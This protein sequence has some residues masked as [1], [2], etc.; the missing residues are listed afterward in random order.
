MDN[1][2]LEGLV[3]SILNTRELVLN[4]GGKNGVAIGM[5]FKVLE[6]DF[7]IR[8]PKSQEVLG[9]IQREKIKIKIVDV[10]DKISI[11]RTY[12]TYEEGYPSSFQI[13]R[14][15]ISGSETKVRTLRATDETAPYDLLDEKSSFVKIGDPVIQIIE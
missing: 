4:I 10:K 14:M 3:A 6:K 9:K 11:G 1:K 7:E 5:K 13:S 2:M 15:M 12:E 8:D